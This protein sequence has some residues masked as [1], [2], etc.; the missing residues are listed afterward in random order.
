MNAPALL[1]DLL[2][3][4]MAHYSIFVLDPDLQIKSWNAGV[5]RIFGYSEQEFLD[6]HGSQ[7]FTEE[8]RQTGIPEAEML[9]ARAEGQSS[10]VR[11]HARKDGSRFYGSGI[12]NCLRDQQGQI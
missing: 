5:E 1:Y 7:L 11:W 8:D 6:L 10:D 2:V 3:R 12:M 9:K 4:R